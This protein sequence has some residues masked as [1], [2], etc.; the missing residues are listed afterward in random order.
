VVCGTV[1]DLGV[2][3]VALI[4]E[5]AHLDPPLLEHVFGVYLVAFDEVL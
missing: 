1:L 2:E 3:D 5:D 4:A